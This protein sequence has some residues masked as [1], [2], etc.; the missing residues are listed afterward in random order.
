MKSYIK[1]FAM[2]IIITGFL[3]SCQDEADDVKPVTTIEV[4]DVETTKKVDRLNK[5]SSL[6]DHDV[7][8]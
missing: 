2:A 5:S 1:V 8:N 7:S 4:D 6:V 3:A